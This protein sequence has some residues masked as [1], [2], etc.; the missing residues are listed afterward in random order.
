MQN[1]ACAE[2]GQ[3]QRNLI[4]PE[5]LRERVDGLYCSTCG[6][7]KWKGSAR[8]SAGLPRCISEQRR[9]SIESVVMTSTALINVT[10]PAATLLSDCA[11]FRGVLD[12]IER[13]KRTRVEASA[14]D[15]ADLAAAAED[16][17]GPSQRRPASIWCGA[18]RRSPQHAHAD[19]RV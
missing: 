7:D 13:G 12:H 19:R 5:D 8:P 2:P 11:R 14:A 3:H 10:A 15:I 6:G 18:W 4:D 16:V 9:T 17:I 1:A